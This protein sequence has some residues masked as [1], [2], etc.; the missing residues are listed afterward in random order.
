MRRNQQQQTTIPVSIFHSSIMVP[1]FV[2]GT[3]PAK[4]P[5]IV[6]KTHQ[7]TIFEIFLKLF[8]ISSQTES[9]N[10]FISLDTSPNVLD[11]SE[12]F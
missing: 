4:L 8:E 6:K 9:K 5:I 2:T 12:P 10:I 7:T 11:E 3:F 1:L